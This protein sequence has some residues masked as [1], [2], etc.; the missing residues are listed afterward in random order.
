VVHTDLFPPGDWPVIE[1][2]IAGFGGRLTL[3]HVEGAGRVY[4]LRRPR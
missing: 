4:A 1:Q 3:R 2:R